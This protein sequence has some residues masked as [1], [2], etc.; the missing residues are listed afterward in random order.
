M[1]TS[2]ASRVHVHVVQAFQG[3][4]EFTSNQRTRYRRPCTLAS[5]ERQP[6]SLAEGEVSHRRFWK[7]IGYL[8]ECEWA[9]GTL[10]H[11]T[12]YKSESYYFKSV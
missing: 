8:M 9:T 5:R 10:A 3:G 1:L 12:K 4:N 6:E 7:S 11:E 2:E